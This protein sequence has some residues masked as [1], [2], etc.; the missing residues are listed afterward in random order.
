MAEIAETRR[1]PATAIAGKEFP[2]IVVLPGSPLEYFSKPLTERIC[3]QWREI[4]DPLFFTGIHTW[5]MGVRATV[6]AINQDGGFEYG[7]SCW[8]SAAIDDMD[9]L[10]LLAYARR[11]TE[12]AE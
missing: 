12:A 1:L 11:W 3:D 5:L 7:P 8:A 2:S 4:A 10:I 9:T 6:S